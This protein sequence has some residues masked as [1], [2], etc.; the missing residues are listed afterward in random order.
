MRH[1]TTERRRRRHAR[2]WSWSQVDFIILRRREC[3]EQRTERKGEKEVKWNKKEGKKTAFLFTFFG[4]IPSMRSA[5]FLILLLLLLYSRI[6]FQHR[7]REKASEQCEGIPSDT[8]QGHYRPWQRNEFWWYSRAKSS[9]RLS[10]FRVDWKWSEC[11]RRRWRERERERG[12]RRV[13]PAQIRSDRKGRHI[14]RTRQ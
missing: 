14:E 7:E 11:A 1:R 10:L 6:R 9:W 8:V 3:H 13:W 2:E 4:Y 5:A 12:G